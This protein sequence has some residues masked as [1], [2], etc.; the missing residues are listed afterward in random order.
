MT[1]LLV[2]G[3]FLSRQTKQEVTEGKDL[4]LMVSLVAQTVKNLP[5]MKKTWVGK[6]PLEK[7]IATHSSVLAGEL[8]GQRSLMDNSPWGCKSQT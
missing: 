3:V 6:I 1:T 8:H 4:H 7:G 2:T 5:A